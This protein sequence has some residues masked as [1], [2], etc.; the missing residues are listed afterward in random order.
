M[1]L[2]YI[3]IISEKI[4]DENVPAAGVVNNSSI[5]IKPVQK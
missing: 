3:Y 5:K 1:A 2:F 4:E